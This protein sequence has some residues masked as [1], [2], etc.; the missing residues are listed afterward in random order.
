MKLKKVYKKKGDTKSK[1]LFHNKFKR[2][3]GSSRLGAAEMNL[4]RNHG[5]S[6]SIPGLAQWV[7]D[8][9]LP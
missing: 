8:P 3:N 1:F 5:V 9:L 6:G 7:K 2:T 4:T